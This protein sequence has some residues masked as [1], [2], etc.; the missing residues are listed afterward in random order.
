MGNPGTPGGHNG[1]AD[2]KFVLAGIVGSDEFYADAGGTA[3]GFVNALYQDLFGRVG[4]SGGVD[5]WTG[6]VE[7]APNSRD[8]IVQAF[9]SSPE[10]AHLLLDSFYPA[11]GGTA[12]NPLPAPGNGVDAGA[13]DLA[14]VTGDGWENL[15]LQGPFDSQPQGNDQFFAELAAGASWDDIQLQL[16]QTDQYYTNPNRP[17]TS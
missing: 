10:A 5:F 7:A 16:L 15:Y 8:T 2:E 3:Q 4:D 12:S 11:P 9:L 1:S 14:V 13:F 6:V 17:V